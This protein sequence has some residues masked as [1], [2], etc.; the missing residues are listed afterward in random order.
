MF[1]EREILNHNIVGM[2]RTTSVDIP[3][4]FLFTLPLI[5]F[6]VFHLFIFFISEAI[7][8]AAE[9]WGIKCLRYEIRKKS[10]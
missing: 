3:F 5:S 7:N 10:C 6:H 4:L 2:W 9:V 8:S 1:Q